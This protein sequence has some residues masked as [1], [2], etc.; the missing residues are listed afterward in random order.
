MGYTSST[1]T[2]SRKVHHV[3]GY[4]GFVVPLLVSLYYTWTRKQRRLLQLIKKHIASSI[5]VDPL[6]RVI[7]LNEVLRILSLLERLVRLAK[8]IQSYP[9]PAVTDAAPTPSV[10]SSE[11]KSV[12]CEVLYDPGDQ[13]RDA[14]IIFIHGIKGALDKTWT[15]G[16]WQLASLKVLNLKEEKTWEIPS[17]HDK[18]PP[19]HEKKICWPRD[20]LPQDLPS[21]RIISIGYTTDPYLWRPFFLNETQRTG[22]PERAWE[23]INNLSEIGVGSRSIIWVGHSKGGLYVKQMLVNACESSEQRFHDFSKKTK[24]IMFY[25]VPHRGS[26]LANLN[27]PW[28]FRQSIELMEV[29]KNCQQ[30]LS[31]HEKFLEKLGKKELSVTVRSFIETRLTLMGLVY[32]R[33]V[34]EESADAEVGELYGIPLDHRNI[35]KP[36]NRDCFLYQQLV[37]LVRE[38]IELEDLLPS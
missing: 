27:F 8:Q 38:T 2:H 28:L 3:S 6:L 5:D 23:M 1:T 21:A 12:K 4:L 15:Q 11:E 10:C 25:S 34:S 31:L 19:T 18:S 29:Q 37:K 17:S 13:Q 32:V 35:C 36:K 33:I 24:A 22:L 26:I 14:D 20:W 16:L 9:S 7:N 30:V